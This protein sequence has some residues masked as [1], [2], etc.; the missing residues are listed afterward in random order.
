MGNTPFGGHG[1]IMTR[2]RPF[3]AVDSCCPTELVVMAGDEKEMREW[4]R[5][6]WI[7]PDRSV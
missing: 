5:E 2:G 6:P 4:T 3:D 7:L 1:S